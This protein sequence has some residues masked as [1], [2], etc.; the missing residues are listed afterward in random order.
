MDENNNQIPPHT[1][2]EDQQIWENIRSGK[3]KNTV[4]SREVD[5]AWEAM[6]SRIKEHEIEKRRKKLMRYGIAASVAILLMIGSLVGY[7]TFV[8]PDVYFAEKG[9]EE[10][11]L[12][13]GSKVLLLKGARLTVEKSLPGK[14][15]E[16][17]LDGNALFKVAKSK[18]H[19][20][21]VHGLNYQT[22]VMGTVFKVIQ[23]GSTFKVD[24]F[25]GQVAVK[26][27]NTKKEYFMASG[28]TFSNYGKADIA[29]LTPLKT[30][31]TTATTTDNQPM[32]RLSF[33]EST[34]KNAIEVIE[35]TY[36]IK[37]EYPDGYGDQKISLDNINVLPTAILGSIAAHLD[38]NL[39]IDDTTY[40]LEK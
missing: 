10:I 11:I 12:S 38:L 22:K 8:K 34:V 39:N 30:D 31:K 19:P 14:T 5:L 4:S 26:K 32:I 17:Y 40:R 16:V 29:T 20:F 36:H 33:S 25:E 21:I 2:E 23:D 27:T 7:N 35:K 37:V 6:I 24:L 9:I 28:Q 15:R 1:S 18:E 3:E 13:D